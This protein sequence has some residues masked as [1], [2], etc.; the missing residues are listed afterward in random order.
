MAE[1]MHTIHGQGKPKNAR[2]AFDPS[3]ASGHHSR[4]ER[5][6]EIRKLRNLSQAELGEMVGLDQGQIS[7]IERGSLQT[8]LSAVHRIAKALSVEPVELFAPPAH[9][10]RLD[11]ALRRIQPERRE[12]ALQI[13]DTLAGN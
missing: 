8:T 3:P 9:L 5:M 6:K 11:A 12:Q 2:V 4:M 1:N 10:A 7:R 13:L